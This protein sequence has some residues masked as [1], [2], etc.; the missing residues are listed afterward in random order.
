MNMEMKLHSA[1][2]ASKIY[3]DSNEPYSLV[4]KFLKVVV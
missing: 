3:D 1:C 2:K 4:F